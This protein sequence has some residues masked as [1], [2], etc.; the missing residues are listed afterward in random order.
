M[1]AVE[2][3]TVV[4]VVASVE[5]LFEVSFQSFS[6]FQIVFSNCHCARRCSFDS[7]FEPLRIDEFL[8]LRK[9]P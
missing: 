9:K 4:V 7:I 1:S 3:S 8:K 5:V 6:Y 2:D